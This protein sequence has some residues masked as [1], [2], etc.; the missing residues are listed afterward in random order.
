[1]QN[2]WENDDEIQFAR[3]ISE[4]KSLGLFER[5]VI[6]ALA[7]EMGLSTYEVIQMIDRAQNKFDKIKAN[8]I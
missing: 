1:M 6:I 2:F 7:D 8:L 4:I 3:L 5:R